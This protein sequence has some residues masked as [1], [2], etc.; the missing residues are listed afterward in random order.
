MAYEINITWRILS[1]FI[2]VFEGDF[3]LC[4]EFC[5]AQTKLFQVHENQYYGSH[6]TCNYKVVAT[7]GVVR[8]SKR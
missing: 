8:L 3:V 5:L 1:L 6:L 7:G 4:S 2:Y